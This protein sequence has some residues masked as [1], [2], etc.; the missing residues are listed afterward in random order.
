[1]LWDLLYLS[2]SYQ[3]HLGFLYF[4]HIMVIFFKLCNN[5]TTDNCLNCQANDEI[6]SSTRNTHLIF[7]AD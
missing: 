7:K 4:T 5:L 6:K 2:T 3:S 1:M